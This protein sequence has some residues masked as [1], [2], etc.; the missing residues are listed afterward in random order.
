MN[1]IILAAGKNSRLDTGKPKSLLEIN[2]MTLMERHI[3]NFRLVG[4]EHFCVVTGHNPEPLRDFIPHLAASYGVHIDL[5]H[6]DRYDL[7]NG[8]SVSVTKDWVNG[9][10][11]EHFFLTMGDHAFQPE[12]VTAF[13]EKVLSAELNSKLILAVD[14]PGEWNRHIDIED[15]TRVL[16]SEQGEILN[17]GKM[18]EEYNCY[19]TGLFLMQSSVFDVL[20]NCFS[21]GEYTISNMVSRLIADKQARVLELSG[22]TWNDVDNPEDLNTT[23]KLDFN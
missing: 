9:H 19:D 22:Y 8:Y 10:R 20:N 11:A 3:R 5:V 18:I 15:V 1:C 14:K 17:I 23:K 2:G 16:A 4:V 7:E 12:F 21:R 13:G 6:N